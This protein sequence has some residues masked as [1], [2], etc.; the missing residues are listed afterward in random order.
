MPEWARRRA[1]RTGV[2]DRDM[3]KRGGRN[4][5]DRVGMSDSSQEPERGSP[6]ITSSSSSSTSSSSSSLALA[7]DVFERRLEEALSGL[8][9]G[10]G[11]DLRSRFEQLPR[12]TAGGV[13]ATA[14]LL[15]EGF[16]RS[17]DLP[18]FSLLYELTHRQI[19]M[20]VLKRLR[21]AHVYVD[22]TDVVQDVFLS[23]YRYPHRFRNEKSS[24]F[25]NWSFSIVRNTLLKH[26]R[27]T[28]STEVELDPLEDVVEDERCRAPVTVLEQG[29]EAEHAA[30]TYAL[31][32]LVYRRAF[33]MGLKP[34]ERRAL[35][36]IEVRG[37][38]YRDAADEMGIR[39]ENLKMIVCRARKK[40]LRMMEE[41]LEAP[42]E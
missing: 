32:L 4:R 21:F 5:M 13:E 20:V 37:L 1:A 38:K 31:C 15:M 2:V 9:P 36:F 28:S 6:G 11:A 42:H 8:E 25:R 41:L 23:I 30:A 27:G 16:A 39:L 26:L 18:V 35:R 34:R 3:V 19:L 7:S 29:E 22:P 12:D 14:S 24:S 17:R 33:Q 40:L 10:L